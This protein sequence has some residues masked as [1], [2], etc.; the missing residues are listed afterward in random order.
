MYLELK[1]VDSYV[2][3]VHNPLVDHGTRYGPCSAI[4]ETIALYQRCSLGMN[5]CGKLLWIQPG[6][7]KTTKQVLEPAMDVINDLHG[8]KGMPAAVLDILDSL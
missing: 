1:A 6:K 4:Y 2:P 7:V 5:G 3:A 8:Y